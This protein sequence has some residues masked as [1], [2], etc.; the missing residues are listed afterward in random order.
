MFDSPINDWSPGRIKLFGWP[1]HGSLEPAGAGIVRLQLP[2]GSGIN[3]EA[4][5][6]DSESA[7][8]GTLQL[9]Q[10]PRATATERTAAEL[11][12]DVAAGREWRP[13]VLFSPPACIIYGNNRYRNRTRGDCRWLYHDGERNWIAS[14]S[15]SMATLSLIPL[16]PIS[17]KPSD[18]ITQI[19]QQIVAIAVSRDFP[20]GGEANMF[21]FI[22]ATTDGARAIVARYATA[23]LGGIVGNTRSFSYGQ[24][25]E[26]YEVALSRPVSGT[27]SAVISVLRSAAEVAGTWVP[28]TTNAEDKVALVSLEMNWQRGDVVIPDAVQPVYNWTTAMSFEAIGD[29][30]DPSRIKRIPWGFQ[31]SSPVNSGGLKGRIIGLWYSG[32]GV[33][34]ATMDIDYSSS[35]SASA[36]GTS[37]SISGQ[38]IVDGSDVSGLPGGAYLLG[39]GVRINKTGTASGSASQSVIGHMSVTIT[40]SA[41][42]DVFST[43]EY[44]EVRN[45]ES[46]LSFSAGISMMKDTSSLLADG[47]A[48]TSYSVETVRTLHVDGEEVY[49]QSSSI[50]RTFPDAFGTGGPGGDCFR[51]RA[52][53]SPTRGASPR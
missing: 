42:G 24:P 18:D 17:R 32:G 28:P 19:D 39:G 33:E 8:A 7:N 6:D 29:S 45:G 40:L 52:E 46:H 50:S 47:S 20:L 14:L 30:P 12:A 53:C 41:G 25:V 10:D 43:A 31:G 16:L 36:I 13:Q 23:A 2:N 48:E 21:A 9:F 15:P 44:R 51:I 37:S 34:E 35:V 1:W 26:Y 49:S 22:D 4:Q 5:L 27:P 38:L 3:L 11:A